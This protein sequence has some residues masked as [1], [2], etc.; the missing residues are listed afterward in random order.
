MEME[1]VFVQK[2]EFCVREIGEETIIL[3]ET[4]DSI[5][6]L[7]EIASVIYKMID[8]KNSLDDI[9]TI[10]CNDYDV[11]QETAKKDLLEFVGELQEKGI[12][13]PV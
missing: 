11:D 3:S 13:I 8:G 6:N 9:L 5:H 4:D 1:T 12:I 7:D 2:D 10:L